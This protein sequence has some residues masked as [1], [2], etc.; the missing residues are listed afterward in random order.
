M[1]ES[2]RRR[3][4]RARLL[5]FDARVEVQRLSGFFSSPY[6]HVVPFDWRVLEAVWDR[7]EDEGCEAARERASE[8]D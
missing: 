2:A 8:V 7:C 5:A 6:N 3:G 4:Q 1:L